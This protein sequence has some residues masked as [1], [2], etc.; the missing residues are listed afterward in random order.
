MSFFN[1]IIPAIKS[2]RKSSSKNSFSRLAMKVTKRPDYINLPAACFR[3]RILS[4]T[5]ES[6]C[7]Q[8]TQRERKHVSHLSRVSVVALIGR[9][10]VATD[11]HFLFTD[12]F[13]NRTIGTKNVC[14]DI[15]EADL[16]RM[17]CSDHLCTPKEA[18]IAWCSVGR[19][20]QCCRSWAENYP[21]WCY[22]YLSEERTSIHLELRGRSTTSLTAGCS[23]LNLVMPRH[24]KM[25]KVCKVN[26]I[27]GK[28]CS[29]IC[30]FH[31]RMRGHWIDWFLIE[32]EREMRQLG[33]SDWEH[34]REAQSE[35]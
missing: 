33:Q 4:S 26:S 3:I 20:P 21:K 27:L 13:R 35:I 5:N 23:I 8:T 7:W 15:S 10:P 12:S 9:K 2:E 14:T 28:L 17:S 34:C 19:D 30:S 25:V 6:C 24:A 29:S 31:R 22:T 32:I 1:V 18:M 16:P 11:P